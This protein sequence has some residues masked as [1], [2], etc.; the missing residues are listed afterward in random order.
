M[1]N[2]GQQLLRQLKIVAEM[3]K[4]NFPNTQSLSKIFEKFEGDDGEPMGCSSRTILRDI[5]HLQLEY[6]APIEYDSTNRGYFL[7][8]TSWEFKCP[9][10]EE[11]FVSM[12]ILGTRLAEDIVPEPIKT[13]IDNAIT[14]TLAN[15]SSEFFDAAMIDSILCASGVKASID[16]TIFKTVFDAWRRKRMLTLQYRDPKG[17]VSENNFEPHVIVFHNGIWY[18]KGYTYNTKELRIYAC[19]RITAATRNPQGF[20]TD[21]KLIEET[22]RNG[23]FNYPKIPGIKLHCDA[24]I[25][26]YIH[27]QQHHFK[28][29]IETQEDGSIILT[30]NPTVE[31]EVM[32]WILGEAGRIQVLEPQSLREKVAAAGREITARNS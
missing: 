31:H 3:K 12:A 17:N 19:Q 8:N 4:G 24:S 30:L 28:S 11:D 25:A 1:S 2:K 20:E 9:V 27:E 26:F 22:R 6:G 13:D 16:E 14:Q 23:V 29:K 32:R 7:R 10:F 15:N 21:K 18:I 5:Q